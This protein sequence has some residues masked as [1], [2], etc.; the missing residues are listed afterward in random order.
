MPLPAHT[1][2]GILPPWDGD[3]TGP[4]RSP[5]RVTWGDLIARFATSQARKEILKGFI[6]YRRQLRA[7]G[8]SNGMQWLNG[9]FVEVLSDRE[10]ND[11]DVVSFLL[12]PDTFTEEVANANLHLLD[13]RQTK[14]RFKC[15]AY[16]VSIN[17][18]PAVLIQQAA[19]W[20]G[21]F[22]HQRNATWKGFVQFGFLTQDE[23]DAA[24][25]Q[26]V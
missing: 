17:N 24:L 18:G 25:A 13:F 12:V 1:A 4:A 9:S 10:P 26:L 2:A 7:V 20:S 23:D 21:L 11:L 22:G 19:Y 14:P 6:E 16:V 5:Y 15:D 3:P 8:L